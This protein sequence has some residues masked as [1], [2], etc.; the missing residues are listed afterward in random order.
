M[1]HLGYILGEGSKGTKGA[2]L[3]RSFRLSQR[4]MKLLDDRAIELSRYTTH[5]LKPAREA[6]HGRGR[7][8]RIET[9]AGIVAKSR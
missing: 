9:I 5:G 4:T 7:P 6:G 8:G 3:Q 2:S 1:I